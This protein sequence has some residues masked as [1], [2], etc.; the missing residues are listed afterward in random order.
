MEEEEDSGKSVL[1][2]GEPRRGDQAFQFPPGCREAPLRPVH[3]TL[4]FSLPFEILLL[5][6]W[7]VH[8]QMHKQ[9]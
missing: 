6:R 1:R 4:L 9:Q 2:G 7:T 8:Y 5:V 3:S